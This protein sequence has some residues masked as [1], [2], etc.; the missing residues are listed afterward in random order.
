[1]NRANTAR[2]WL[3]IFG[4]AAAITMGGATSIVSAQTSATLPVADEV[5][6]WYEHDRIYVHLS[7]V[8]DTKRDDIDRYIEQKLGISQKAFY[9]ERWGNPVATLLPVRMRIFVVDAKPG[10]KPIQLNISTLSEVPPRLT[11]VPAENGDNWVVAKKAAVKGLNPL[12]MVTVPAV[13]PWG[14]KTYNTQMTQINVLL[15]T[16]KDPRK[17]IP[18]WLE[19]KYAADDLPGGGGPDW[20]AVNTP[21]WVIDLSPMADPGNDLPLGNLNPVAAKRPVVLAWSMIGIAVLV[22]T[23]VGARRAVRYLKR[24]YPQSGGVDARELLW[25][26]L[27]PILE[28]TRCAVGTA[29]GVTRDGYALTADDVEV[30][31][32][33]VATFVSSSE[34]GVNVRAWTIDELEAKKFTYKDGD[35]WIH[36]LKPLKAV[37]L[38]LCEPLPPERYAA[39]I[40]MVQEL[41]PQK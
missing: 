13:L 35:R 33:A 4:L 27:R 32:R 12:S 24:R 41:C 28:R 3:L 8:N 22:I 18:L 30:V 10:Q 5:S 31:L 37:Q 6:G 16:F 26:T 14:A 19:F 15:Q 38:K 34:E 7:V 21:N 17:R 36:V 39:L 25:H 29:D 40:A 20:K 2:S 23:F 11:I 1:M 9:A